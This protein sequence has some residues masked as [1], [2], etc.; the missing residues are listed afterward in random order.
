MLKGARA[1]RKTVMGSLS[2]PVVLVLIGVVVSVVLTLLEAPARTLLT[3]QPC[4]FEESRKDFGQVPAGDQMSHDFHFQNVG[5]QPLEIREIVAG[6]GCIAYGVDQTCYAPGEVGTVTVALD[7][8]GLEAPITVEKT[9]LFEYTFGD[10]TKRKWL[11]LACQVTADITVKPTKIVLKP[12]GQ[13]DRSLAKFTVHRGM[14]DVS[15]FRNLRFSD[16]YG[17]LT[18]RERHRDDNAVYGE[19]TF[20]GMSGSRTPLSFGVSYDRRGIAHQ[21]RIDVAVVHVLNE[22]G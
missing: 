1:Y 15:A 8:D 13:R 3:S 21:Q 16:E 17:E 4:Q 18:I 5:S 20:N 12:N 11:K 6:C 19:I 10:K 7:T 22:A 2:K 9:I 14:L